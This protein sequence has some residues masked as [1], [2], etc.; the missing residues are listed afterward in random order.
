MTPYNTNPYHVLTETNPGHVLPIFPEALSITSLTI[1][2]K[3]K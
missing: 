2:H 1:F 3:T